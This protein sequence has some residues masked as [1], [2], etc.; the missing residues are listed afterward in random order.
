LPIFL[1]S[2]TAD[3]RFPGLHRRRLLTQA[4]AREA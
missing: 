4:D 2:A 1:T 3:Y